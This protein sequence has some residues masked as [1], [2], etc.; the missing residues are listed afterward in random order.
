M[1][2]LVEVLEYKASS[3]RY[4]IGAVGRSQNDCQ[5]GG[6]VTLYFHRYRAGTQGFRERSSA[7]V[8]SVSE[9]VTLAKTPGPLLTYTGASFGT[10]VEIVDSVSTPPRP[11]QINCGTKNNTL[12]QLG[13]EPNCTQTQTQ[14][15]SAMSTPS[16][17]P[18]P[19]EIYGLI[20]SYIDRPS[21]TRLVRVC[22]LLFK[23]TAPYLWTKVDWLVL[24]RLLPGYRI[25]VSKHKE[26]EVHFK[27]NDIYGWNS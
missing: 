3:L 13:R 26:I 17:Q 27:V 10:K 20:Y 14:T 4:S 8:V 11:V 9:L 21:L 25:T 6:L 2:R 22:H 7:R 16:H 5:I 19:L 24:F 1:Y 12:N 18:L 15:I 23:I